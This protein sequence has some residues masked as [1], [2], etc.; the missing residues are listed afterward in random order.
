MGLDASEIYPQSILSGDRQLKVDL[1]AR[2]RIARLRADTPIE[3]TKDLHRDQRARSWGTLAL[4][5]GSVMQTTTTTLRRQLET[6]VQVA[7]PDPTIV[8]NATTFLR[9]AIP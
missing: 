3:W 8:S 2:T 7:L 1:D 9:I 5:D 4:G 6:A